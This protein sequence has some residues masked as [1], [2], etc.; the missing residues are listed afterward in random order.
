MERDYK[1]TGE[2]DLK[3]TVLGPTRLFY[4]TEFKM[5]WDGGKHKFSWSWCKFL[6]NLGWNWYELYISDKDLRFNWQWS[7]WI[8]LVRV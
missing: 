6:W 8:E 7:W 5:L 1:N 4:K 3:R 2:N